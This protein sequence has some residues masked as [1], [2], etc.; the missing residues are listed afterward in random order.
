MSVDRSEWEGD[1]GYQECMTDEFL[2]WAKANWGLVESLDSAWEGWKARG[3][4]LNDW[5]SL[6]V[7]YRM[8]RHN[9]VGFSLNYEEA[10]DEWY[11]TVSSC[12]PSENFCGRSRG[13]KSAVEAVVEHLKQL[14]RH[15]LNS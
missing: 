8:A 14:G 10:A 15:S 5:N 6:E 1:Y 11:C 7:V 13:F 4:L 12:A 2:V 9:A 3:E